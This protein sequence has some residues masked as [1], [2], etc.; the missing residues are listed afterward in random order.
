MIKSSNEHIIS[1]M[2][3]FRNEV[4]MKF[5]P[6]TTANN[7]SRR[8]NEVSTGSRFSNTGRRRGRGDRFGGRGR[9][10]SG[11]GSAG[12][13]R[14][15]NRGHPNARFI[16]C[17]NGRTSEIHPSYNFPKDIWNL[18]PANEKREII[19]ERND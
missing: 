7:R 18:I 16:T 19:E 11:G 4:N 9:G 6:G 8:I 12:R 1:Q 10:P 17:T 13:G 3:T 2:M 15:S 14:G 5:P